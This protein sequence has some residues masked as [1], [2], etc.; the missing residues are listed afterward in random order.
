MIP[1][2]L[3]G[4]QSGN[5]DKYYFSIVIVIPLIYSTYV[6]HV[7]LHHSNS[8]EVLYV[9]MYV[10]MCVY[11]YTHTDVYRETHIYTHDRDIYIEKIILKDEGHMFQ[12]V[13]AQKLA[14]HLPHRLLC[15]KHSI[16]CLICH[17]S[18][19]LHTSTWWSYYSFYS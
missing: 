5:K 3:P 4:V 13:N 12:L 11:I 17:F 14:F 18:F 7:I 10:H 16:K 9:W 1:L 8:G 2:N 19:H 15:A 6:F